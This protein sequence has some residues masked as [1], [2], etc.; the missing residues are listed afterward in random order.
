MRSSAR[1]RT[2]RLQ[3]SPMIPPVSRP[4]S[5]HSISINATSGQPREETTQEDVSREP[6]PVVRGRARG[7]L[8]ARLVSVRQ[9]SSSISRQVPRPSSRLSSTATSAQSQEENSQ[10]EVSREATP[11]PAATGGRGGRGYVIVGVRSVPTFRAPRM[12]VP[13]VRLAILL[14]FFIIF[15][16]QSFRSSK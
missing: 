13:R 9:E 3:S 12:S 1:L 10:G 14:V 6:A 7:R 11:T 15:P 5:R 4:R 2:V 8:R 16:K